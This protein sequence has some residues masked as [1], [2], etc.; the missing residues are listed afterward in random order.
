MGIAIVIAATI[1]TVSYATTACCAAA[2]TFGALSL[3]LLLLPMIPG[4]GQ[5]TFGALRW[6]RP[7]VPSRSNPVKLVKV[8][9]AILRRMPGHQP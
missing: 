7:W 2:P 8:T 1:I 3:F 6:I 5:E 4:L 9:L